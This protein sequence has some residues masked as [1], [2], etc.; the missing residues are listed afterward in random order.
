MRSLL[1]VLLLAC[2]LPVLADEAKPL[3]DDPVIEQRM[4]DLA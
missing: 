3:A 2:F 4:V 1:L